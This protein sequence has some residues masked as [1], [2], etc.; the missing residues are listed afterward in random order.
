M[1]STVSSND[2][3]L[4]AASDYHEWFYA[5]YY[6]LLIYFSYFIYYFRKRNEYQGRNSL[7]QEL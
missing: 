7:V 3:S 2:V 6:Y 5:G 1:L 4:S